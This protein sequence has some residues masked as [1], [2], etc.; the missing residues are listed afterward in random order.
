MKQANE[1]S[2]E[3]LGDQCSTAER[4]ER[5]EIERGKRKKEKEEREG[6]GFS[7]IYSSRTHLLATCGANYP[8]QALNGGYFVFVD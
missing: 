7:F 1:K 6:K 2:K 8:H 5:R 4:G 3:K